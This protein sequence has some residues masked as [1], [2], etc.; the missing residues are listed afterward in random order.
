[1]KTLTIKISLTK[2]APIATILLVGLLLCGSVAMAG[3][4]ESCAVAA[5]G[6]TTSGDPVFPVNCT[7]DTAG[8]LDAWMSSP[9]SYTTTSGVTSGFI[10]SAV[11]NDG[12]TLDFYYQV[13]NSASSKDGIATLSVSDFAPGGTIY[14]TDAAYRTDGSTLTG[15][16][17]VNGTIMPQTSD[18]YSTGTTVQFEFYPPSTPVDEI[19][20]GDSSEVVVVSTN[21][22][23][24]TAGD[25]AVIDSGTDTVAS[26][27]PASPV[28]EPASLAL[29]GLG[30]IGLAGL[31]RRFSR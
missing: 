13:V 22:T 27:Q 8:T 21:A 18:K 26:F 24:Y 11:Y 17:F 28:P 25:A 16:G 12:G 20:P 14:T 2:F 5:A 31:R 29:M 19:A 1:M 30:L 4:V 10:Y 6:P 7:G 23:K 3:T 15:T 9:F